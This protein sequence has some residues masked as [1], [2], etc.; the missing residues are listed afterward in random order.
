MYGIACLGSWNGHW[1]ADSNSLK[2]MHKLTHPGI[3]AIDFADRYPSAEVSKLCR[4][5]SSEY[6]A[7]TCKQVLGTDLSPTQPSMVPPN[8]RFEID[9]FTEPWLFK[10]NHFD[11]IHVRSLY[12]CVADWSTFYREA[13]EYVKPPCTTHHLGS[14]ATCYNS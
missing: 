11:F 5:R 1:Y 8:V 6:H 14:P 3:W 13:L 9:D 10:K 2:A 12:G 4:R 7:K